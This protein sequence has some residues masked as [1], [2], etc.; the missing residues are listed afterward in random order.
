[1]RLTSRGRY[2]VECAAIFVVSTVIVVALALIYL[3]GSAR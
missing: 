2:L 3:A 1:M